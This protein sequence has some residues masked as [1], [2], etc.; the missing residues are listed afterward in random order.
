MKRNIFTLLLALLGINLGSCQSSDHTVPTLPTT[1]TEI[2]DLPIGELYSWESNRTEMLS[3]TDMVLIYGG[4]HHRNPYTWEKNRLADYVK[5]TDKG[6][7][8]HWLFDS[9][10]FLEIMDKGIGGANKMFAKGYDLESAN[11]ADW[12]KLI[13]YYFQSNTGIGALDACIKDATATLGTPAH[14]RQIIISIPE[15]IV[16]QDP[17][18]TSSS[19]RYWGQINGK[20]LDFSKSED[21]IQACKWYIDRVRA[22][23]NEMKY[24]NVELG[25]FYWLAE[26][27]TDTRDILQTVAAY[28][29]KMKYSF[30][31]IPYYGADGYNQW[32][33]FGF[34]YAYFQPNYFWFNR[35]GE[36][37]QTPEERLDDACT[38]AL[39]NDMHV[40]L[41]FDDDALNSRGYGYRLQNYMAKFK[42]YGFWEK[43]RMAYYQGNNSLLTLKNSG[44]TIDQ[45]LYHEFCQFVI[46]RPIR[47]SH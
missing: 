41:E 3:S 38:K 12:E 39:N 44:N 5:Y 20:T 9:F 17:N 15:P 45:D 33:S 36:Y 16:Y 24:Q 42:E 23:F 40:E 28:L 18:N 35:K 10:L 34:N 6:N 46:S 4:G 11:K 2:E 1:P 29:N 19:T 25:G 21:R 37:A 27:A 8:S 31:W 26:K 47:D 14:K 22:K 43:K 32:K 7:K 13:D 30:N